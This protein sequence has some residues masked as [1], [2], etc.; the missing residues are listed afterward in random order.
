MYI[1]HIYVFLH[2]SKKLYNF[3]QNSLFIS[4][5]RVMLCKW[6]RGSKTSQESSEQPMLL[7]GE[8]CVSILCMPLLCD[9]STLADFFGDNS[10]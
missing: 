7:S 10:L 3:I 6:C 5:F 8:V 9:N 2:F 1:Y 4:E